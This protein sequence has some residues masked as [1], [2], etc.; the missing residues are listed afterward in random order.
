MGERHGPELCLLLGK[1]IMNRR[2]L[3][4]LIP[5]PFLVRNKKQTLIPQKGDPLPRGSLV[6][7]FGTRPGKDKHLCRKWV[8]ADGIQNST[9]NGGSGVCFNSPTITCFEKIG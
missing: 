2:Q 6:I 1:S 5:I 9:K 8:L 3:L 4:S 7:R